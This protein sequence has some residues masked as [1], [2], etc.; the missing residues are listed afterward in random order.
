MSH[1]IRTPMNGIMAMTELALDT[2]LTAEAA[3]LSQHRQMV[4]R[5]ALDADHDILDFSKIEAGKIELDPIEFLLRDAIGDTLNPLALRA[6][7][8]GLEL[9]YD[10]APDVPDAL[11]CGHSSPSPGDR[12]LVGNAIKFT[13][14]GESCRLDPGAGS[15]RPG[16]V[17]PDRGSRY[18]HR[19]PPAAAAKLFKPFEQADCRH[20]AQIWGHRPGFWRSPNSSWNSWVGRFAW[21]RRRR[22]R[23]QIHLHHFA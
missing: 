9:A 10:I 16:A 14:K 11:A 8:K 1:E 12:H 2:E 21:E 3:R 13:E 19:I 4:G 20:H 5:R 15:S 18:R 6:A 23:Q 22:P 17:A 7:S